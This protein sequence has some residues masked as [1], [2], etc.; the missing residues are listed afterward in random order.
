MGERKSNLL[1]LLVYFHI[2]N[3]KLIIWFNYQGLVPDK[4]IRKDL[5]T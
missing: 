1:Y 2:K 4:V 5:F 3:Q